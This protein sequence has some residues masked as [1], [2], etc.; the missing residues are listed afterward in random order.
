MITPFPSGNVAGTIDQ[1]AR[2]VSKEFTGM[3]VGLR[4]RMGRDL[5]RAFGAA[6]V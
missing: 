6:D 1:P 4:S 3:T 2:R 5:S